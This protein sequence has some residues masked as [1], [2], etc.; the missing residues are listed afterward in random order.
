MCSI[1]SH[2]VDVTLGEP[3]FGFASL[4]GL[5]FKPVWLLLTFSIELHEHFSS[6]LAVVSVS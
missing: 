2:I 3:K 4:M 6:S 5:E 1:T